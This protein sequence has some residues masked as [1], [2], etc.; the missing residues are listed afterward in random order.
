MAAPHKLGQQGSSIPFPYSLA[1]FTSSLIHSF[2][3][4]LIPI[5][6]A[7]NPRSLLVIYRSLLT[8]HCSLGIKSHWG[9]N[10]PLYG[11]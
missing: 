10:S 6:R 1:P 11:V 2:A 7:S 4:S 3:A 9:A 5:S 8:T